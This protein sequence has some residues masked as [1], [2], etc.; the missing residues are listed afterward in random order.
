M[1][2]AARMSGSAPSRT[3]ADLDAH[4]P[5]VHEHEEDGAVV[6]ALLP[7]APRLERVGR[8]LLERRVR[9]HAAVDVDEHLVRR[10]ALELGEPLVQRGEARGVHD[11]GAVGRVAV[12]PAGT[13]GAASALADREDERERRA[14]H[15]CRSPRAVRCCAAPPE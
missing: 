14:P 13:S 10:L 5:V 12:G 2:L 3:V 7:D 15:H 11:A 1:M 9:R 4:L 8:E 6:P